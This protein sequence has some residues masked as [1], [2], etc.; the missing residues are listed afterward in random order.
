MPLLLHLHTS[1]VLLMRSLLI[2]RLL[3]RQLWPKC[4][5][6]RTICG[7]PIMHQLSLGIPDVNLVDVNLICY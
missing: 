1:F 7:P 6:G 5:S 3:L 2:L 4:L